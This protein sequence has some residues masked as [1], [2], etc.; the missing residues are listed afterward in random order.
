MSFVTVRS[1]HTATEV[2]FDF[3]CHI[4]STSISRSLYFVVLLNS[5]VDKFLS[6]RNIISVNKHV[7]FLRSLMVV[8]GLLAPFVYC[9]VLHYML[10]VIC[11]KSRLCFVFLPVFFMYCIL[12]MADIPV[13]VLSNCVISVLEFS[14]TYYMTSRYEM[15]YCLNVL[16]A[17]WVIGVCNIFLIILGWRFLMKRFWSCV[18]MMSL[19]ISSFRLPIRSHWWVSVWSTSSC[20][21]CWDIVLVKVCFP[22]FVLVI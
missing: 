1:A 7:L 8:F 5:P 3:R 9:K 15:I 4:H 11:F 17:H 14:G 18:A 10:Y 21:L 16:V 6:T 13:Y 20:W 12:L 22:R 2:N 19:F